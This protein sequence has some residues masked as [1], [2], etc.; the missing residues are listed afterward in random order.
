MIRSLGRLVVAGACALLTTL[1]TAEVLFEQAPVLSELNGVQS[2]GNTPP[3]YSQSFSAGLGDTIESIT[4]W[5]FHGAFSAGADAFALELDGALQ[6]GSISSTVEPS[7]ADQT[8]TRYTFVLSSGFV[9]GAS[10]LLAIT[11][12]SVDVEWYWQRAAGPDGSPLP[13]TEPDFP[14]AYRV[15]GTSVASAIPEPESVAMYLGGL[16]G[17]AAF[18]LRARRRQG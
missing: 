3:A 6:S 10:T 2:D 17:V 13:G 4:W 18:V 9:V 14:V 12:D 7:F 1:A 16:L 5:G 8:L 11:N 15:E